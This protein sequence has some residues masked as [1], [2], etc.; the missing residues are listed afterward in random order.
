M[1][2]FGTRLMRGPGLSPHIGAHMRTRG[3]GRELSLHAA[4]NSICVAAWIV[5]ALPNLPWTPQSRT[6]RW[7]RGN[8]CTSFSVGFLVSVSSNFESP[9]NN[10]VQ[11]F[12]LAARMRISSTNCVS[13]CNLH[14]I[15]FLI[16]S[17]Y[18]SQIIS[19]PKTNDCRIRP[20]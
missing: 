11:Y 10:M 9:H 19:E 1:S 4:E 20:R 3:Q 8:T 12:F 17:R 2:R 18:A 14:K 7:S 13:R 16:H 5:N 6:T 15:N